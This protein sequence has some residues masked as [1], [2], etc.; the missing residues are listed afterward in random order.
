MT[1]PFN[2]P[3][4]LRVLITGAAGNIGRVLRAQLKG[5]YALLRLTDV[6]PQ[7]AAGPGEEVATADIRDPAALERSMQGID[8]VI[9]LAGVPEEDAWEKVLPLNIEGC[10][11]VFEA[12]R[13][14][15]VRRMVGAGEHHAA[16]ALAARRLEHVVAALDVE[17]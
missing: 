2:Q 9:H 10:Y 14:Q 13:S 4:A 16:H 3:A 6:V 7:E 1:N 11:N 15:G 8:C 5:R 12:A 17:R